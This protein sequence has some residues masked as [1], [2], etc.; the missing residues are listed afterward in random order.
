MRS[1]LI[2]VLALLLAAPFF[3]VER[4]LRGADA[5]VPNPRAPLVN[6]LH[7]RKPAGPTEIPS[8]AVDDSEAEWEHVQRL[9]GRRSSAVDVAFPDDPTQVVLAYGQRVTGWNT[10]TGLQTFALPQIWP[11]HAGVPGRTT[12]VRDVEVD[13]AGRVVAVAAADEVTVWDVRELRRTHT[14][15]VRLNSQGT[16]AMSRDGRVLLAKT[17]LRE[18][19]VWSLDT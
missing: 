17:A 4:R 9:L 8:A 6:E 7:F 15:P 11:D 19:T 3:V 12:R 2:G 16:L 10:T 1:T 14:F 5:D 18:A 13:G